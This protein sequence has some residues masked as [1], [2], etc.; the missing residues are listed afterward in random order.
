MAFRIFRNDAIQKYRA[1]FDLAARYVYLAATAYD[2]ETNLL[3]RSA[4]AGRRIPDRHR[5]A[6]GHRRGRRRAAPVAGSARGA[7]RSAGAH[8]PELRACS[9]ASWASTTRRPRPTASRC[10]R[11][12]FRDPD[13]AARRRQSRLDDG[14]P[15][16]RRLSRRVANSGRAGVP[17]L[18]PALQP[19]AGGPQPGMV[20][21]FSTSDR[22]R[23]ELL[24]LAA[25]AAATTPTTPTNFATKVRSVGVWFSNY[26]NVQGLVE[27]AAR[28]P[29]SRGHGHHALAERR[30]RRIREWQVLD[31]NLPVPF[32]I[33]AARPG[34]P[35][36][37]PDQRHPVGHLG[38]VRQIRPASAPITT[39]ASSTRTKRSPTAG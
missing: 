15:L 16:A 27:H 37:D 24:R 29:G 28:L 1:Q 34:R 26:N 21:P 2:Y 4:R 7:G 36:L 11:E 8:A 25:R 35:R 31:Q 39:A 10:A 38:G 12:L 33:G 5:P 6:A 9:R 18:L 17:P 14:R 13:Q 20:I 32:P 22:L 30:H 19:A 23:A 3:G